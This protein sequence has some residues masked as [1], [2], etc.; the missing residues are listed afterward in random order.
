MKNDKITKVLIALDYDPTAQKVAET[1]YNMAK[2]MSAEVVLLHVVSDMVY[3]SSEEYSPIMGFNGFQGLIP[4]PLNNGDALKKATQQYL[5]KTRHH[6]GN[7][8]IEI[9]AEEGEVADTIIKTAKKMHADIIV[10]GSHSRKWLKNILMGS[11]TE[12]VM[13]HTSIPLFIVPTKKQD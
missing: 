1:G 3:Y 6:L 9:M 13:L 2:A 7:D 11:V 10:M 4:L 5:E 12:E 8:N